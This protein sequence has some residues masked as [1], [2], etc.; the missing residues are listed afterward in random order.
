MTCDCLNEVDRVLVL[1]LNNVAIDCSFG[2]FI[3]V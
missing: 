1:V 3:V 2:Q